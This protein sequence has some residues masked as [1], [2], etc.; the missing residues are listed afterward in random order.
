MKIILRFVLFSTSG[1]SWKRLI[2]SSVVLFF[3]KGVL[4]GAPHDCICPFDGTILENP[5][6][7][8]CGQIKC[9]ICGEH[10]MHRAIYIGMPQVNMNAG[11]ALPIVAPVIP[12][13]VMTPVVP[14]QVAATVPPTADPMSP[15]TITYTNTISGVIEVKC[16]R[17]HNGPLR[18]LMTYEKVKPYVD[19]GLLKLLVQ[20]GGPMNRFAGNDAQLIIDWAQNGALK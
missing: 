13:A 16:A 3:S 1:F 18:N 2:L 4:A 7:L 6:S 19:N 11:P 9:P 5:G 12:V 14:T 15:Q 17:C 8:S 10:H 20:L